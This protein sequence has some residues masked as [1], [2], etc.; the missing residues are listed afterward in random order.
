[1]QGG[2]KTKCQ[3][4]KFS[5]AYSSRS[6]TRLSINSLEVYACVVKHFGQGRCS[7]KTIDDKELMCVIR[8]KFKGRSKRNNIIALGSILLVGLREWEGPDNY[9]ICD[10]LEI[11]DQEDI[12]Q[13]KSIP[14]TKINE[15]DKYSLSFSNS[16]SHE[17]D[18]FTFSN[19]EEKQICKKI[20]EEINND[21]ENCEID[22]DDI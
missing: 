9:K 12:N 2:N 20:E 18:T 7:V 15:L 13:L 8:S 11:Y 3:A 17:N 19:E 1:M 10:V 4:R 21:E 16:G 14:S 6:T 5:S 22:I